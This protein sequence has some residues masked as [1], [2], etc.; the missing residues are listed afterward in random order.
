MTAYS[1]FG[2]IASATIGSALVRE[3]RTYNNSRG[4]LYSIGD[5]TIADG[6]SIFSATYGHIA[7]NNLHSLSETMNGN[8]QYGAAGPVTNTWTYG[9]D[10]LNRL[11]TA[12]SNNSGSFTYT[13]DR[14]GNRWNQSGGTLTCA[15]TR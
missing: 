9:Y 2:G 14:Y 6:N 12:A 13:Y 10:Y 1:R 4:W 11:Q 7:N 5:S 15:A 3:L 8:W